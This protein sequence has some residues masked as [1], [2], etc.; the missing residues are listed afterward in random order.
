MRATTALSLQMHPDAK[1]DAKGNLDKITQLETMGTETIDSKLTLELLQLPLIIVREILE[2]VVYDYTR[3][4]C[5]DLLSILRLRR[6][7]SA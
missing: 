6:V 5:A 7:N 1:Q 3:H 2:R 4:H